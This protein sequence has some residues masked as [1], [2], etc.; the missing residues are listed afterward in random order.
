MWQALKNG[1][2]RTMRRIPKLVAILLFLSLASLGL[3]GWISYEVGNYKQG[4]EA[5]AACSSSDVETPAVFPE[6]AGNAQ[7]DE[8]DADHGKKSDLDRCSAARSADEASRIAVRQ[9]RLTAF[10]AF[11]TAVAAVI[12]AWAVIAA[13][14]MAGRTPA[15]LVV[16][17]L[18]AAPIGGGALLSL[19]N[20]GSGGGYVTGYR[21][22]ALTG[23]PGQNCV[24]GELRKPMEPISVIMA[25][26]EVK[27]FPVA[28]SLSSDWYL[29]IISFTDDTGHKRFWRAFEKGNAALY[30]GGQ[31]G[32][33]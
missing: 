9:L 22:G 15:K 26:G 10:T 2:N 6:E 27:M 7:A 1:L 4:T 31:C 32:E 16:D 30:E 18:F 5:N 11:L 23:P 14:L 28:Q 29:L 20:I 24:T 21:L 3:H 33:K 12:A 8:Q 13:V 25:P 19:R 17:A